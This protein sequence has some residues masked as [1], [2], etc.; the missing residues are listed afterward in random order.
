[1]TMPWVKAR[2]RREALDAARERA[3]QDSLAAVVSIVTSQAEAMTQMQHT[4]QAYLEMFKVSGEPQSRIPSSDYSE[5]LDEAHKL[6]ELRDAGFPVDL[7]HIEQ[8]KW[9]AAQAD[10]VPNLL[11]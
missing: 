2:L 3:F 1:M 7:S 9:V 5:V 11:T 6:L 10:F 8:L 4:L